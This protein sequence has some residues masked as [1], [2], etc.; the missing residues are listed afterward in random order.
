MRKPR[1]PR[2]LA[3][4]G[5]KWNH[6]TSMYEI[7]EGDITYSMP[8]ELTRS[9]KDAFINNAACKS[10]ADWYNQLDKAD[11]KFVIREGFVQQ[12]DQDF[13]PDPEFE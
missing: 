10:I 1:H 7:T 9:L 6:T 12:E 13:F 11:R 5:L 8:L 4:A 2:S 3:L